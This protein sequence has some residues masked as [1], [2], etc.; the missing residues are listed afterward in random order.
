M[1]RSYVGQTLKFLKSRVFQHGNPIRKSH[2]YEHISQ[3][4]TYIDARKLKYGIDP[5]DTNCRNFL[6]AHFKCLKSNLHNWYER[7]SY[8]G[9]CIIQLQPTLN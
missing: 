8:E 2:V 1:C 6:L 3:C 5:N 7:T 4:K 9:L